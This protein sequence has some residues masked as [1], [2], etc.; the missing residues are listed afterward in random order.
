MGAII[1]ELCGSN[2]I[3]KQDGLFVCQHCGTKYAPEDAKKLFVEGTVKVDN[4][5]R[6]SN[7]YKIA[8]RAKDDNNS[9]SAEK[10][11]DMILVEDPMSWEA[12]FYV[13]Y[14]RAM[15]CKIAQIQSAA[16]SIT[17]CLPSVLELIHSQVS[18]KEAQ[19]DAIVDI[20]T[21]T[22]LISNMLYNAAE[23][24]FNQI[25]YQ[26]REN[27]RT[28]FVHN[29]LSALYM[30]YALGD[31][32]DRLWSDCPDI[33]G[34]AAP[35]WKDAI[36]V[37]CKSLKSL[38]AAG[39]PAAKG[40]INRYTEKVK[41]YAPEYEP[42]AEA[43][44]SGGCYVATAVYGSY[45]CPQVW[46]LRRFRDYSLANTWYGRTFIRVYYATSPTLV[47]WFGHTAWI[48]ELW[49]SWLDRMVMT[50]NEAGFE[51]TPY[52]DRHW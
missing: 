31:C 39:I 17:N 35:I 36:S 42:P 29:I 20:V 33:G 26:I 37:H 46:T 28:E 27:Y 44:S 22:C 14:F 11:Y 25:N 7:L 15:Q 41:K 9:E 3:T 4:S 43:T 18:D 6:L 51:D 19:A 8:R 47:K 21:H 48:K 30:M 2:D 38:P 49:K 1:C 23:N 52:E 13:V 24:H 12:T 32:I 50:L 40:E 34:A 10:Y 5:E 16:T 45:D